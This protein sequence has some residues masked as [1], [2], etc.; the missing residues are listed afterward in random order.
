MLKP[1]VVSLLLVE[2][3]CLL[4]LPYARQHV[5]EECSQERERPE[6]Q[7]DAAYDDQRLVWGRPPGQEPIAQHR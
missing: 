7:E 5:R 3:E 4:R 6:D 2:E 1:F